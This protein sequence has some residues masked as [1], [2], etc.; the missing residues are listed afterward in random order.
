M[1]RSLLG[2]FVSGAR[3]LLSV[4]LLLSVIAI[5][6]VGWTLGVTSGVIR[7][8]DLLRER[9]VQL[10]STMA[11]RGMV[12]PPTQTV[13]NAPTTDPTAPYPDE[14]GAAIAENAAEAD[15][16]GFGQI[17]TG[18]FAPPPP[19][20]VVV[21]HVRNEMDAQQAR[22]LA[23]TLATDSGL[24]VIVDV[25]AQGDGRLSGYTYFDGRQNRA[26]ADLITAF[27]DTARNAGI[28]PW[29]AQLRGAALPAQGEFTADRLD[30]VLPPLPPPP[31]PPPVETP[32]PSGAAP[33]P[34]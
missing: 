33:A 18:L 5:A 34:G 17:I 28:A 22:A 10:E 12:V 30:L 15:S 21:L 7:E 13:V 14:V 31:A 25:M 32:L 1:A 24:S 16:A 3:T 6:L 11:E 2:A 26:A 19:M 20:R 27:L 8:R 4:Q 29:S 23:Q 9:V